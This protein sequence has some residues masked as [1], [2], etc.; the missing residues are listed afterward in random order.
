MI[1]QRILC[2]PYSEDD[3]T[4][5]ELFPAEDIHR[6]SD[7]LMNLG[8]DREVTAVSRSIPSA[9]GDV[10]V[11]RFQVRKRIR[12]DVPNK[13]THL[14]FFG[15]DVFDSMWEIFVLQINVCTQLKPQPM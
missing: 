1:L 12:V 8:L 6:Q 15:C 9:D 14:D 3:P 5:F 11:R 10:A 13:S 2:R 4:L 7:N